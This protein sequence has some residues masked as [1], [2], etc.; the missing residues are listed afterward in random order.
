MF[1][2]FRHNSLLNFT[3]FELALWL[4]LLVSEVDLP[5]ANWFPHLQKQCSFQQ[6]YC[7]N[8]IVL[9]ISVAA[10]TLKFQEGTECMVMIDLADR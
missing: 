4:V 10:V 5:H 8:T 3:E 1:C 2:E 9:F 6:T 7:P